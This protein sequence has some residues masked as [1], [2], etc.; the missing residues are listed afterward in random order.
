MEY[1]LTNK[2]AIFQSYRYDYWSNTS[3][4]E[5]RATNDIDYTNANS[6]VPFSDKIW[7]SHLV[8][9]LTT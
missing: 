4:I 7:D 1:Y 8:P 6:W 5:N 3:V 2:C 9:P